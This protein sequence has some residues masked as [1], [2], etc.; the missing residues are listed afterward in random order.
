MNHFSKILFYLFSFTAVVVSSELFLSLSNIYFDFASCLYFAFHNFRLNKP[1][2]A[3]STV[4]PSTLRRM[5]MSPSLP[6]SL[7]QLPLAG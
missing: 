4:A 3:S 1:S 7:W 2:L 5:C 6:L